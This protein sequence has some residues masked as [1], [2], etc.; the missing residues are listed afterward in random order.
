M[1]GIIYLYMLSIDKTIVWWECIPM[2]TNWPLALSIL[3]SV[4]W[5]SNTCIIVNPLVGRFLAMVAPLWAA[6]G[7][8]TEYALFPVNNN[9]WILYV[10]CELVVQYRRKYLHLLIKVLEC[11]HNKITCM[12]FARLRCYQDCSIKWSTAGSPT[13]KYRIRNSCIAVPVSL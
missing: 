2:W 1:I 8:G 6:V 11:C 12:C 9:K 4:Q 7:N 10:F 5:I 13:T 3:S